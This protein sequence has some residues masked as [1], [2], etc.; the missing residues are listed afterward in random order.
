MEDDIVIKDTQKLL[1][2]PS[3]Q[4][5]HDSLDSLMFESTDLIKRIDSLRQTP[6]N[7][8]SR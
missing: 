5:S 3:N 7:V 1:L 2:E 6:V 8:I 4:T